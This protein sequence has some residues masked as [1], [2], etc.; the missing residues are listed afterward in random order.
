[1][2]SDS[3]QESIGMNAVPHRFRVVIGVGLE[4]GADP[5]LLVLGDKTLPPKIP[6]RLIAASATE[7]EINGR[8]HVPLG[9]LCHHKTDR[10]GF[11]LRRPR[12]ATFALLSFGGAPDLA[13]GMQ[14]GSGLIQQWMQTLGA[15]E[16]E[17]QRH[18][19]EV[20]HHQ[21]GG[22][23]HFLDPVGELPGVGDSGG[24]GQQ[25]NRRRAV[26]DGLLPD[27][28]PLGVIHVVALVKHH[29]LNIGERIITFIRFGVEHVAKDLGGHHHDR[30]LAI[31]TQ[32]TGHQTDVLVSELLSEIPQ[33]LVGEGLQRSCVED[34]LAMGQGAIN[35]VLTHERLA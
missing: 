22:P 4:P 14:T 3:A 20:A 30:G 33:L 32:I 5:E 24:E 8:K 21:R 2:G 31:H 7:N 1:M 35:G 29:R 15:A 11:R 12:R 10:W 18:R 26:N 23:V 6:H 25:L 19:S 17:L 27:R 16:A 13:V 9:H 34:L 28:A